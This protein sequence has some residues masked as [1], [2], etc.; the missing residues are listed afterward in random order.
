MAVHIIAS[1][2]TLLGQ[3]WVLHTRVSWCYGDNDG[4][5]PKRIIPVEHSL[6]RSYDYEAR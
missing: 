5:T 3:T 4:Y 6:D 1:P 2:F